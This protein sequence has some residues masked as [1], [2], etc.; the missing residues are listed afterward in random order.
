MMLLFM[1]HLDSTLS[2][3]RGLGGRIKSDL[4]QGPAPSRYIKESASI[5]KEVEGIVE[6]QAATGITEAVF[7]TPSTAH[8]LGGAVMGSSEREGVIN[9]KCKVF[10]Y[11]NMYVCDGAAISANPG[12]NPSLSITAVSEWSMSHIPNKINAASQQGALDKLASSSPL[13]GLDLKPD[14]LELHVES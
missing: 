5:T 10:G 12:V 14:K 8:I 9:D 13:E 4:G 6:G 11:E 7:G 3:K 2:L 1:Q